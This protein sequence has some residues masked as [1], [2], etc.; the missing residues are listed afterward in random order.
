M[1]LFGKRAFAGGIKLRI[2]AIILGVGWALNAMI[3]TLTRRGRGDFRDT[4]R[5]AQRLQGS[6]VQLNDT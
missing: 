4:Q 3:D 2:A 6:N 5:R 1:T